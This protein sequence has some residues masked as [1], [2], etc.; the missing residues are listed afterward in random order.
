[1]EISTQT[2]NIPK[3]LGETFQ[4]FRQ[5]GWGLFGI[6]LIAAIAGLVVGGGAAWNIAGFSATP[7]ALNTTVLPYTMTSAQ[8][9]VA[10]VAL[11]LLVVQLSFSGAASVLMAWS[12]PN[13]RLTIR[14]AFAG[15]RSA[16]LQLFWLQWI[17]V[18]LSSQFSPWAA[19]VLWFL[20]APAIPLACIE[21]LGPGEAVDRMWAMSKGNR[22][23]L[24]ILEVLLCSLLPIVIIVTRRYLVTSGRGPI[25]FD[26]YPTL[27]RIP[28]VLLATWLAGTAAQA[29]LVGLTCAYRDLRGDQTVGVHAQ[30]AGGVN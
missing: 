27:F 17:V 18:V 2:L 11:V 21:G 8:W 5:R 4:T 24:L 23:R 6:G 20:M 13:G 22:T 14:Q 19:P 12:E 1:M 16:P 10:G 28:F 25:N 7:T 30:A 9:A 26:Q 15:V 3:V 29:V